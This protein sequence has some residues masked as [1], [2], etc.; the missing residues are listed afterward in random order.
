MAN[1]ENC[2]KNIFVLRWYVDF[3]SLFFYVY[4]R[5]W[6]YPDLL[7]VN[8]TQLKFGCRQKFRFFI[9]HFPVPLLPPGVLMVILNINSRKTAL[10]PIFDESYLMCTVVEIN[11]IP[12][13]NPRDWENRLLPCVESWAKM[14]IFAYF[15]GWNRGKYWKSGVDFDVSFQE[16]KQ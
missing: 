9:T 4:S 16:W 13:Y 10:F 2:L 7:K 6:T 1:E 14:S 3:R 15:R 8:K 11:E 12:T 5:P